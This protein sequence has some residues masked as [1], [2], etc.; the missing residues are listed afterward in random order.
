MYAGNIATGCDPARL[1][2][3]RSRD[4]AEIGIVGPHPRSLTGG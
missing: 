2:G 4:T 3:Y 1:K